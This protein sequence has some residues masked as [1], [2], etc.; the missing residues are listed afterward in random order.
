MMSTIHI[1]AED[2][3]RGEIFEEEF[4]DIPHVVYSKIDHAPY[5]LHNIGKYIRNPFV[6]ITHNG[7][8][9]VNQSLLNYAKTIPNLKK[10][11]GQNIECN[12]DPLIQSIP[13]GLENDKN[14][15]ELEKRKKL[16]LK[17]EHEGI[18]PTIP[19]RLLYLNYSFSTNRAERESSWKAV[20]ENISEELLTDKCL[21]SIP[22]AEYQLW[23]DDVVKHHYVLCPRGN[24]IDTHRLW[25]TLYLGRIPVVKRDTNNSFYERLPILFVDSWEEVNENLLEK[26]LNRL[27]NTSN[28]DLEPLTISWWKKQITK[29]IEEML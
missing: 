18:S 8:L 7:D 9:P 1:S 16:R 15:P 26:N 17:I 23:L 5:F 3:I 19:S 13:I 22:Q 25:E 11:Y 21:S 20:K 28:F 12:A 24:G 2:Y 6:L 14:F 29:T 4:K 10:W 27:S